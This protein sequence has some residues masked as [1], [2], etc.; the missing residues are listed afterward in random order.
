MTVVQLPPPKA[1][2]EKRENSLLS[3]NDILSLVQ[4]QECFKFNMSAGSSISI[5]AINWMRPKV[6]Q[7]K[8]LI[9]ERIDF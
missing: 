6:I 2:N 3:A 4:V 8:I 9:V 1:K 7:S 5:D